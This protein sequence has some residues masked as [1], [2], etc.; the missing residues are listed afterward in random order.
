MPEMHN[1]NTTASASTPRTHPVPLVR[2]ELARPAILRRAWWAR[3]RVGKIG[4]FLASLYL[5]MLAI[6]LMKEGSRQ[7]FTGYKF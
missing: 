1:P 2:V 7:C 3:I 5:F 4:L 6:T